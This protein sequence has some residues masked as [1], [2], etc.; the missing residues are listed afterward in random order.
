M[1]KD[2]SVIKHKI[3]D[4]PMVAYF[5][6]HGS[7]FGINGL[8]VTNFELFYFEEISGNVY[9]FFKEWNVLMDQVYQRS[10]VSDKHETS[11]DCMSSHLP[12]TEPEDRKDYSCHSW[13]NMKIIPVKK[14]CE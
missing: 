12:S 1:V 13:V 6:E 5:V 3:M 9:C 14:I 2:S 8:F 4:A 7:I 11:L 10:L